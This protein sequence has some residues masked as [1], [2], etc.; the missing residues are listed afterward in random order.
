MVAAVLVSENR[1]GTGG[2]IR[3][4]SLKCAKLCNSL[5]KSP[6]LVIVQVSINR[7]KNEWPLT[8]PSP[9]ELA[10]LQ[11]PASWHSKYLLC[12]CSLSSKR[13]VS[14]TLE[15]KR[16]QHPSLSYPHSTHLYYRYT[17][18]D[19]RR[20]PAITRCNWIVA[21]LVLLQVGLICLLRTKNVTRGPVRWI[22]A[23]LL[24]LTRVKKKL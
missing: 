13:R 10:T 12:T 19:F 21:G 24:Q 16:T 3:K 7:Q 6:E 4:R 14:A 15:S 1:Y 5:E 9:R 22:G 11:H 20:C 17:L 23:G 8:W 18:K 2:S